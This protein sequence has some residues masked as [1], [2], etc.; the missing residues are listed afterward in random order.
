[1]SV[2]LRL[3]GSKP[4]K[5]WPHFENNIS[6]VDVYWRLQ[7]GNDQTSSQ[8]RSQRHIWLD[9]AVLHRRCKGKLRFC[10]SVRWPPQFGCGGRSK[11]TR[12]QMTVAQ[13]IKDKIQRFIIIYR[14]FP[15]HVGNHHCSCSEQRAMIPLKP[16]G[17]Q[18][19]GTRRW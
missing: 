15:E 1:M 5:K 12:P 17:S 19:C 4:T 8:T 18:C 7:Y 10:S 2:P 13:R 11:K 6:G 9:G 14:L 3:Q 16:G